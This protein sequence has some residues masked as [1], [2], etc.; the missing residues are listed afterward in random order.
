MCQTS[1]TCSRHRG[2]DLVTNTIARK[3]PESESVCAGYGLKINTD[4]LRSLFG[5]ASLFTVARGYGDCS[6]PGLALQ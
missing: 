4:A 1:A 5:I 6:T 3:L 2:V